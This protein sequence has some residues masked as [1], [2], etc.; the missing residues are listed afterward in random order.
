MKVACSLAILLVIV[1][2]PALANHVRVNADNV[3]E[4]DGRKVF[5]IGFDLGPAPTATAPNGHNGIQE[6]RDAGATFLQTGPPQSNWDAAGIA[7]ERAW[8]DA[9]AHY[10]MHT[11]VRLGTLCKVTPTAP[12]HE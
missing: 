7:A 8:Q 12:D 4:I 9:A 1:A 10:G 5:H 11:W 3:I 2:P 6:L